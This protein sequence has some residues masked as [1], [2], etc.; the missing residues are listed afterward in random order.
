MPMG[1]KTTKKVILNF[2]CGDTKIPE[3]I[4][5][6]HI[7]LP[8]VD[9]VIDFEKFPYPFE[10]N[11]VDEIHMYFVLE[12]I[13]NHLGVMKELHR[14]LKPKGMLYIRV[15]HGS[16]MYGQWGEF[17]HFR[18]YS[19]R[20]FEIFSED[21]PRAYYSDVRF[22]IHK[23][24]IKYFLTYPYDWYKF[25]TWIPHWEKYWYAPFVK[26]GVNIIQG[27]IDLNPEL[28]ERF[29]CFWVGGAAEVYVELEKI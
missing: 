3:A 21:S 11:S 7:K 12:H 9:K 20:S 16:G 1:A 28:F 19:Y 6:D 5:I 26:F 25:N 18:G 22:K 23:Q 14:I 2:G 29:W 27:L 13:F 15:P 17:T 24:R 10:N 8:N 4:N